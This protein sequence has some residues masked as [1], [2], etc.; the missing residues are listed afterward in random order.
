MATLTDEQRLECRALWNDLSA[1]ERLTIAG[2]TKADIAAAVAGIDAYFDTSAAAINTAI[3]QPARAALTV[4][5]KA[6]LVVAVIRKRYG[7]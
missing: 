4:R 2:L 3:P 5:Q 6:L 7:V 1:G